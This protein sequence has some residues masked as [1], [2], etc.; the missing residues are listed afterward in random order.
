MNLLMEFIS[1]AEQNIST[2]EFLGTLWK[3]RFRIELWNHYFESVHT[4]TSFGTLRKICIWVRMLLN[5][6]AEIADR[7]LERPLAA[8]TSRADADDF[9]TGMEKSVNALSAKIKTS[10]IPLI[11]ELLKLLYELAE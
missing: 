6:F 10:N 7:P 4:A 8:I 5:L 11:I 1:C 3:R 2:T 9:R